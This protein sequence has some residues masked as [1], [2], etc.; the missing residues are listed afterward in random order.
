MNT[1]KVAYRDRGQT[2]V[3]R[4]G[5][6]HGGACQLADALER[7]GWKHVEV[8]PEHQAAEKEA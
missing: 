3:A 2:K 5:L 6:S 1:Y 8:K 4:R 7:E